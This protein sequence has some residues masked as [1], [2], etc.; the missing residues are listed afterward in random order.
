MQK[1]MVRKPLDR[2]PTLRDIKQKRNIWIHMQRDSRHRHSQTT[3]T[4]R[5]IIQQ[6]A[7]TLLLVAIAPTQREMELLHLV[8]TPIL[9]DRIQLLQEQMPML[10]VTTAMQNTWTP[11]PRDLAQKDSQVIHTRKDTIQLQATI[12]QMG[13]IARTQKETP[14]QLQGNSPTPR[15]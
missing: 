4:L 8:S 11:M 3:P 5:D 1:E 12:R 10:K 14:P 9:K 15:D 13:D 6:Q 7:M 2:T